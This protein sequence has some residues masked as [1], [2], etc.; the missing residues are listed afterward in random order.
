LIEEEVAR[1]AEAEEV[2]VFYVAATEQK[3]R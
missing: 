1:R 2:R 3:R